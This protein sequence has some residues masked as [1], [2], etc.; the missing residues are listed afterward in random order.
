MLV[1]LP[2]VD[3]FQNKTQPNV[4]CPSFQECSNDKGILDR[5]WLAQTMDNQPS[6]HSPKFTSTPKF[7]GMAKLEYHYN[8]KNILAIV[9]WSLLALAVAPSILLLPLSILSRTV[10]IQALLNF[11]C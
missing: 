3:I 9:V 11:R 7:I 10:I 4:Y 2:Y 1:I 5:S 6:L 8:F